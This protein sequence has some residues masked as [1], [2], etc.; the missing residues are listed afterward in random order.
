MPS[1]AL[2]PLSLHDALPIF[3]VLEARLARRASQ[4]L[5]LPFPFAGGYVG[6]FGYELKERCGATPGPHRADTPDALWMFVD[7]FVVLDHVDRKSTRLNSSHP[8]IS[9]AVHR[10]LPSFPTRRSSDLRRA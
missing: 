8:S 5:D 3:A 9:Y 6:Y 10:A 1:T 7:R 4:P 2:Y